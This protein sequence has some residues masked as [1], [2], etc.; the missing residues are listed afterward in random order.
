M[1]CFRFSRSAHFALLR[2]FVSV[3][4][5]A[6]TFRIAVLFDILASTFRI[7][8]FFC[9]RNDSERTFRIA[10]F[11]VFAV[12]ERTFRIAAFSFAGGGY[13]RSLLN[14]SLSGS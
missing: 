7:A 8:V 6:R 1:L 12:F 13:W 9:F 3:A 10:V 11:G 2:F 4:I 14:N 5:W